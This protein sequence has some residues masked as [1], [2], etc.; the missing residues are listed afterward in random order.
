M[1]K[2]LMCH[3]S[4]QLL[5]LCHILKGFIGKSVNF[6]FVLNLGDETQTNTRSFTKMSKRI[7]SFRS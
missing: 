5:D 1:N 7:Y 6:D 4:S 3:C 2:I